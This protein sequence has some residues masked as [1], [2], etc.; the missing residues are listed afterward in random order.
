MDEHTIPS[1]D[2]DQSE[3]D[4]LVDTDLTTEANEPQQSSAT[5]D[6][7][8]SLSDISEAIDLSDTV[9][10]ISPLS[11]QTT[12][13]SDITSDQIAILKSEAIDYAKA[14][15]KT[16]VSNRKE[17][18]SDLAND[19]GPYYW[20]EKQATFESNTWSISLWEYDNNHWQLQA[21]KVELETDGR[22]RMTAY[23]MRK[24][25]DI[26]FPGFQVY[27]E[28]SDDRYHP[29]AIEDIVYLN[30]VLKSLKQSAQKTS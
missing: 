16:G 21:T 30:R 25:T 9:K 3:V 29:A 1:Q 18:A 27:K 28:Q 11:T 4:A 23:S 14:Y 13:V 8:L 22:S 6:M 15:A 10:P 20:W 17:P 7:G 2:E 26:N 5:A 24:D 12:S 19:Q